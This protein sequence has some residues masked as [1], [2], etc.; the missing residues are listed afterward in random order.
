[1]IHIVQCSKAYIYTLTLQ[2]PGPRVI[3]G[4]LQLGINDSRQIP[5]TLMAQGFDNEF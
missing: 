3:L 2:D 1:M 5:H 4:I